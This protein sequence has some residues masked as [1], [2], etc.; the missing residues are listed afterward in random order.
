[1]PL[2]PA[3][4]AAFEILRRVEDEN[5]YASSLLATMDERLRSDDRGLCHELVLGVLRR[6]LWLDRVLEHFANRRMESLDLPVRL[7]LRLALYQLRFLSRIPPSAAVNDSVNLVRANGLSSAAGFTNA[8][9][10][11]ATR[12]AD[13]DPTEKVSDPLDKLAIAA[14]HPRWLVERWA[15][16]LGLE[17]ASALAHANNEPAPVA[18]RLT[19]RTIENDDEAQRIFDELTASG[20]EVRSSQI[21]PNSWRVI[22][23][24]AALPRNLT[25]PGL[26][27]LQDEAS[28]LVAHFLDAQTGDRV[29]DVCA[30][31]GSKTTHIGAL[32]PHAMIVASDLYEHRLRVLRELATAQGNDSIQVAVADATRVLPFVNASFDRVLVDA[33]CSGTGTLRRNPEIRWRLNAADIAELSAKQKQ[34]LAQA[35]EMVRPG[36]KLLYTTCS[37]ESDENE[38]VAQ[39]FLK[40]HTE[41]DQF[42]LPNPPISNWPADLANATGAVRT[43]PHRHDVDGFFM[44]AFQRRG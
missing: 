41:F 4:R 20:V 22:G 40:E 9:L 1:M 14:S 34:I 11:R 27:Y 10:R 30:A 26:I 28:Q 43:W 24:S 32:A 6:Q 38:A 23:Q 25:S 19:T 37:L 29:L 8:V 21:T 35:A 3:R 16:A 17:E 2:S 42:R 33:P 15:N 18:F 7:A 5:A 12:E 39:D 36:G 31:P 44:I 13:Y